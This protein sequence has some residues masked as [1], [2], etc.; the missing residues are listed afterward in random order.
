[1][2]KYSRSE[3]LAAAL[4]VEAG[5]SM[6]SVAKRYGMS[7]RVVARSVNVYR[8][9]GEA[10]FQQKEK[11]SYTAGQKL[12]ILEAMHSHGWSQE[13]AAVKF[14]M[15]GSASIWRWEQ[16][17]LEN[18]MD[19]LKPKKKGRRPRVPKEKAPLTPYEKLLAENEYLRAENEYL[20]KLKALVAEREAREKHDG[21]SE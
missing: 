18:G 15:N 8:E 19:G 11:A 10:W 14:G 4:A 13:E 1:M 21:A 2:T 16:R 7:Q 20:K 12:L 9:H 3:R 6:A 5:D 17:Y